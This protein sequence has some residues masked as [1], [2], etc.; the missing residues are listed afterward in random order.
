M[1]T[2]TRPTTEKRTANLASQARQLSEHYPELYD[3]LRRRDKAIERALRRIPSRADVELSSVFRPRHHLEKALQ[4]LPPG[5]GDLNGYAPT[6]SDP[7]PG[8]IEEEIID[9]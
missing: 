7:T 8:L 3:H 6:D 5:V 2:S 1:T 4:E 9:G